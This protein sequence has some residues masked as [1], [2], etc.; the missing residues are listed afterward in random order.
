MAYE[1][2]QQLDELKDQF[3][4]NVNHEL[5]TPAMAVQ[6]YLDV[7]VLRHD[8]LAPERRGTMLAGPRGE[9]R[10]RRADHQYPR[11]PRLD[12]GASDFEAQA[13]DVG[14]AVA[15]AALLIAPH[16]D[17]GS[18]ATCASCTCQARRSGRAGAPGEILTNLLTNAVKYSAAGIP[19]R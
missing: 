10:P 9:R 16:D 4:T 15:A 17:A 6:G 7:L 11:H 1:R 19:S 12:Q 18:S 13:M 8:T 2:A 14:G 5:R 3:I